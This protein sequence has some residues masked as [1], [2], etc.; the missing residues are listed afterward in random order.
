LRSSEMARSLQCSASAH[1]RL[2]S[3][4]MHELTS[5]KQ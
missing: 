3:L 2:D 5:T 1:E 4:K